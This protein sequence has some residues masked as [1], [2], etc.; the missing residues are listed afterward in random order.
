MLNIVIEN[1]EEHGGNWTNLTYTAANGAF[2]AN[3]VILSFDNNKV[4][5]IEIETHDKF[6]SVTE[7]VIVDVGQAVFF[8]SSNK[9][10]CYINGQEILM[11]DVIDEWTD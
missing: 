4:F 9:K 3:N 8:V 6:N 2:T 10:A 11:Y 5:E 1:L 7:T